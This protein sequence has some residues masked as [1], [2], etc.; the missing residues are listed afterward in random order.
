MKKAVNMKQLSGQIMMN[1]NLMKVVFLFFVST[2]VVLK[3]ACFVK[4]FIW[5]IQAIK[6]KVLLVETLNFN[7]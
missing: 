6:A 3:F 2:P 5:I 1:S 7:T 4:T